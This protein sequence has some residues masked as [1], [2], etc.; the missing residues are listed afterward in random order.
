MT[1]EKGIAWMKLR[2]RS[3]PGHGS[4]IHDENAVTILAEAVARL[5]ATASR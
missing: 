5:G 4:M 3:R 2:V 1:A